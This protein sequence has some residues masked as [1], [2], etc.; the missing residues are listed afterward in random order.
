M[1]IQDFKSQFYQGTER[2]QM[3]HAG[4]SLM[5]RPALEKLAFCAK[6]FFEE[7]AHSWLK[8]MPELISAKESL[9][10]FLDAK[11]SE[12]SYFQTTAAAISQIAFGL[13]MK[14]DDE[15]LVWD[16]EYPSNFYPWAVAAKQA[17]AK[18]I[19]V[20]SNKDLSTPVT[21]LLSRIT[22]KTRAI[23]LSW[24]Q[25]RTG[26]VTDLKALT[27][28]TRPKGIFVCA[29]I[30]QG[31][32]VY[33]F[34]FQDSGVDAACGGGHKW[35]MSGH[36]AGYMVVREAILDQVR[37]LMVGAMTYGTPED[38]VDL[39]RPQ[40]ADSGK[41]EPGGKAF[42]EVLALGASAQLLVDVGMSQ[43][44][45][46]VERLSLRMVSGLQERGYQIHSPHGQNF[47][48]AIL[49]F[50]A[51]E[52]SPKRNQKE[53]EAA[54]QEGKVSFGV[55]P[56]GVRLAPHAMTRDSEIDRVLQLLS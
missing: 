21:A 20:P 35:M 42:A 29:D 24:V 56:P 48:G 6:L 34:S 31:A 37:P 51:T 33:P 52:A 4:Q 2:I 30:I 53:I 47:R 14:P 39:D 54:L 41:F 5:S 17:G 15:I 3:N 7:G 44:L 9:A 23:G 1:N 19:V 10:K 11:V 32:G 43:I 22:P 27:A 12:I 36:G 50:S 49:N 28:E 16:Q 55:R 45:A 8:L 13:Q 38:M 40:R 46:E 18:L 26:A 25:Y